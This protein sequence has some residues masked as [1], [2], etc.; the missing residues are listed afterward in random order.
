VAHPELGDVAL[1]SSSRSRATE[2]TGTITQVL[3]RKALPPPLAG[4]SLPVLQSVDARPDLV[5]S[6]SADRGPHQQRH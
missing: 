4:G 5:Q 2:L 1:T 3:L 6:L